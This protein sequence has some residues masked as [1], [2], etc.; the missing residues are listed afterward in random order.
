[1]GQGQTTP[2]SLIL[3]H[4]PEVKERALNAGLVI[5]KGK[6]DTFCSAEWPTF[7]VGWPIQGSLSLDLITKVKAVIFQPD[8]RGHPDQVPYIL[9]WEDLVRNPPP[10]LTVFL[11]HPSSSAPGAK[12]PV[13]PA[14]VIKEEEKLPLPTLTGP[15][16]RASPS[17]SPVLPES[18]PLYPS[19]AGAEEDRPPPYVTPPGQASAPEEEISSSSSTGLAAGGGMGQRLRPRGIREREGEDGPPS[20][21]QGEETVPTL[22]VRMVGQGGPGGGQQFQYWPFSSSDLYNWR[23]QNP[24]FSEDPKCLIDLLESIM[25]THRPTWDDCHQLLNTL[26]T[27]EERERILNE[28]RKNVLGDNGRPTTL[29][30]AIDEAFPLRR[31]DWDFGTAEGRERLRIYRQTLM[32]GLRAAARRPTNFAKVKAVIQGENESPAGFLERLHEAYRQYTPIDPE[33][34]LHRSAVV[35]SFIN[36]AAPDIRRKLNKQENLGEMTIREMLQ[37][38]EKVFTARET[39][40]E[41]EERQ[42][43]EDREAQEKLRKEDRE[44]QAKENRKQQ[45]E[46]ARIFLA[47]VRDQPR[48][49]GHARTPDKE[50]CFYCKETGHWKRECPKLKGRR[51]F[52]RRPGENRERERAVEQARVLLAGEED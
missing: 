24:P 43:K 1:M 47:G 34:D 46:M 5:K 44:F 29:Q 28:A 40:E 13:T 32:A 21:T 10:W 18:S 37:V 48:G 49:G 16:I 7:G 14:L 4:F 8:N 6:F 30:P 17:P 38:A 25:H 51:G 42:R 15:Q 31:P 27:T 23:T 33:A 50:H 2:K 20:S 19:L 52:G 39:P 35:L 26:F 36:Q 3:S 11:T 45:R 41:R 22:P 9:V 12:T